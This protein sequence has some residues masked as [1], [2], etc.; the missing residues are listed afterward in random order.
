MDITNKI[1]LVI[2]VYISVKHAQM[3][4]IALNVEG[5]IEMLKIV[6]V[7]KDTMMMNSKMI[8]KNVLVMNVLQV[9]TVLYVKIIFKFQNVIVIE[10]SMMI[11]ALLV[12]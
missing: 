2:N 4:L 5:S 12:K 9:I 6:L 1:I 7:Q 8:V 11:G 3:R 10:F